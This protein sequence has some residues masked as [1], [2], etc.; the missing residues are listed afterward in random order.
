MAVT[1]IPTAGIAD[2]AVTAAKASG[3]GK[4]LQIVQSTYTT[5][6]QQTLAQ[7]SSGI[8]VINNGSGDI[9]VTITPSATSSK[10]LVTV[11]LG[12]VVAHNSSEGYGLPFVLRR[13][14]TQ[15]AV[16]TDGGNV[17]PFTWYAGTENLNYDSEGVSFQFLDTP[18]TTSATTYT[19]GAIPHSSGSTKTITINGW[20]DTATNT[21][22]G[23]MAGAISMFQAMEIGA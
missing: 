2:D 1:T 23:Y 14:T 11:N 20:H 22:N 18:S 13:G 7:G 21:G 3:F 19:L 6:F 12:R 17:P 15:I 9:G 4:V 10:I 16:N 8:T 5:R